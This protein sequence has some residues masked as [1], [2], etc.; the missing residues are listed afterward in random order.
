MSMP[1]PLRL[2]MKIGTPSWWSPPQP[3]AGSKV[4]RPATTAPVDMSSSTTWPLTPP[5]R[6]RVVS[7]STPGSIGIHS[8]SRWPPSPSPLSRRSLGP[9]MKPATDID[10]DSTVAD[11]ASPFR[12]I[13]AEQL[14]QRP[15]ADDRLGALG[16]DVG[17]GPCPVVAALDQQPLRLSAGPRALEREAAVQL[18]AVEDE[19][20]VAALERLGPRDA[21]A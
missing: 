10:M 21:A 16:H 3:P 6:A 13:V 2:M 15:A 17:A 11:T 9:A 12:S 4:P 1:G 19:D 14:G 7:R 8:C 5:R 18:L 20:R